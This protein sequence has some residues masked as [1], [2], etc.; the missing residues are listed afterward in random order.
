MRIESVVASKVQAEFFVGFWC[1]RQYK[2][3][4]G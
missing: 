2:D 3:E 4:D 1:R